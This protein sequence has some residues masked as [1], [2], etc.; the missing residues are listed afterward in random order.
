[1]EKSAFQASCHTFEQ[2]FSQQI[3][4]F[5]DIANNLVYYQDFTPFELKGN[6]TMAR[7]M[8]RTLYS[9]MAS[10]PTLSSLSVYFFRDVY[11]YTHE[12][13]IKISE[14]EKNW[15]LDFSP[16]SAIIQALEKNAGQPLYLPFERCE[17]L[18]GEQFLIL[19][20]F[21]YN[22]EMRGVILISISMQELASLLGNQQETVQTFLFSDGN[23]LSAKEL[24]SDH[25][26]PGSDLLSA[27]PASGFSWE[28]SHIRL[29]AGIA[30]PGL[31]YVR[32]EQKNLSPSRLLWNPAAYIILSLL[33]AAAI[34]A[35]TIF[36][37]RRSYR[38]VR[39]LQKSLIEKQEFHGG[40]K[41]FQLIFSRYSTLEEKNR[42][43]EDT[44]RKKFAAEQD[45]ILRCILDGT[46]AQYDDFSGR[47]LDLGI[48]LSAAYHLLALIHPYDADPSPLLGPLE[49]YAYGEMYH[50]RI[51][52]NSI[53][54]IGMDR[55]PPEDLLLSIQ[56]VEGVQLSAVTEN[57]LDLHH[58]YMSLQI[59][60]G[61]RGTFLPLSWDSIDIEKISSSLQARDPETFAKCIHTAQ[62]FLNSSQSLP[63]E[64][65]RYICFHILYTF[66]NYAELNL[67][68]NQ[69][70]EPERAL[71]QTTP[72]GISALLT[73]ESNRMQAL[74]TSQTEL[75]SK[76][77]LSV[78][79]V[80]AYVQKHY[81]EPDFSLQ[82]IAAAFEVSQSYL[83]TF[84]RE[85]YKM[86][87]LDYC[88]L[89][90]MEKAKDLLQNTNLTLEK[91][92]EQIGYFNTSSFIRRFKQLYHLTP[93]EFKK[94]KQE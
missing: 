51:R 72:A 81:A 90:R 1:M 41:E 26:F 83:S 28:D 49:K 7:R 69:L 64:A 62:N 14:L 84:F 44:V 54:L 57:L 40:P 10:N 9:S 5:Q 74:L 48:D 33:T 59:A 56:Q 8:I 21:S 93:G 86:K 68:G 50:I 36:L 19:Y 6:Y 92:S 63:L 43:L 89:L 75:E 3:Q 87:L 65:R 24:P 4:G 15:G 58:E 88:T 38:P 77:S 79:H 61:H 13:S 32:I 20:P 91:I 16:D 52:D 11:A 94:L 27:L 30:G 29:Y 67:S 37:A 73:N 18:S 71:E 12:H 39:E 17:G 47:A 42:Q 66:R 25:Y 60:Q 78:D 23:L 70:F 34:A 46:A 85:N 76:L 31:S 22:Y 80:L 45:Y 82:K 55:H 2:E 35:A 53:Y